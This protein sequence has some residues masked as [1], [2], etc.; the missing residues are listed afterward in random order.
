[1]LKQR[2]AALRLNSESSFTHSKLRFLVLRKPAAFGEPWLHSLQNAKQA[3]RF[4]R[5]RKPCTLL[6][7]PFLQIGFKTANC[8]VTL[9]LRS[10]IQSAY[11]INVACMH[12]TFVFLPCKSRRTGLSALSSKARWAA[13]AS[14]ETGRPR[15]AES[16][17]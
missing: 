12:A 1:M 2:I 3:F 13:V 5:L 4:I 8:C 15:T 11:I 17:R 9:S 14:T 7:Y 6:F 16:R 10:S